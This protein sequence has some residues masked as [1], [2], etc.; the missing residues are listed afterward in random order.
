M[1][2]KAGNNTQAEKLINLSKNKPLNTIKS[3]IIKIDHKKLFNIQFVNKNKSKIKIFDR[4]SNSLDKFT[5]K[6]IEIINEEK[7]NIINLRT[8]AE[9]MNVHQRRIYDITT[10]FKGNSINI[11]IIYFYI[12]IGLIKNIENC[13]IQ[14]NP[15]FYEFYGNYIKYINHLK[16]EDIKNEKNNKNIKNKKTELTKINNEIRKISLFLDKTNKDL[17]K[18]KTNIYV[19][20]KSN[21]NNLF[22]IIKDFYKKNNL[23]FIGKKSKSE[24]KNYSDIIKNPIKEKNGDKM[25]GEGNFS[26]DFF[27]PSPSLKKIYDVSNNNESEGKS[28]IEK[29]GENEKKDDS[30]F[31]NKLISHKRK[32]FLSIPNLSI[33]NKE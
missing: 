29:E 32:R 11:Y 26:C 5:K 8:I 2:K 16:E 3:N 12:G 19:N 14:I 20:N 13:Q 25:D 10:V 7:T 28:I 6:F 23:D 1:N 30:F 17:T 4:K 27:I 15:K 22:L 33:I 18:T 31:Y 24:I 9:K 21:N